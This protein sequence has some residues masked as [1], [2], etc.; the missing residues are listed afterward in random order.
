MVLGGNKKEIKTFLFKKEPFLITLDKMLFFFNPKV[1]IC[2]G[3]KEEYLVIIR[4]YFSLVL[5]K[6]I[7]CGYSSEAPWE[8]ASN[9]Y[10]QHMFL[11]RNKYN[12]PK[13]II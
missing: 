3:V 7:C 6:N 1:V 10:P 12:Y 13:I 2:S 11:W 4:G 5:H 9:E 8:G